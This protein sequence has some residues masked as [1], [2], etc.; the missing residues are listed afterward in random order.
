MS[1]RHSIFM[2]TQ[3]Q[4]VHALVR[5]LTTC[6]CVLPRVLEACTWSA[7]HMHTSSIARPQSSSMAVLD[8]IGD[9]SSALAVSFL[10][11]N[12]SSGA[13]VCNLAG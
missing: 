11:T 10:C 6:V 4:I 13:C 9:C 2:H 5:L 12:T 1:L 3:M 8:G 7:V